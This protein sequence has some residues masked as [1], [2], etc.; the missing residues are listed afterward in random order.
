MD[1]AAAEEL[2]L[3]VAAS[4]TSQTS[5]L[6][7]GRARDAGVPDGTPPLLVAEDDGATCCWRAG[8]GTTLLAA[9]WPC[10]NG[11]RARDALRC[12]RSR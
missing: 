3:A 11:E 7:T 12:E 1:D 6:S 8:Q 10:L 2:A 4:T 5:E 9:L